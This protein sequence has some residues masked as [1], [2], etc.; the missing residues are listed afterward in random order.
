MRLPALIRI[1]PLAFR[2]GD[3]LLSMGSF[4]NELVVTVTLSI[5]SEDSHESNIAPRCKQRGMFAMFISYSNS[6]RFICL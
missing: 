2:I 4:V 1:S 6:N 3:E 5:S